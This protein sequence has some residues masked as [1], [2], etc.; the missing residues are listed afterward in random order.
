MND[1][2]SLTEIRE[3]KTEFSYNEITPMVKE[4]IAKGLITQEQLDENR[5]NASR[6]TMNRGVVLSPEEQVQFILNKII[7]GYSPEE[8]VKSDKTK[9]ITIH[10]VRYQKR[11]LIADGVISAEEAEKAMQER[12]AKALDRKHKRLIDKIKEYTELGYT[13][14]EMT[15]FI[16]EYNYGSIIEI[17]NKYAKENGWYTKEEL[18]KFAGLRK[19]REAEEAQRTFENLPLEER[20]K[21]IREREVEARRQEEE[22]R[23]RQEE[24]I[25]RRE[26]RKAETKKKHQEDINILKGHIKN[27]KTMKKAADLMSCSIEYIYRLKRES[28]QEGTWL[29]EEEMNTIKKQREKEQ[30][31]VRRK[32]ERE[33][34]KEQERRR[35]ENQ[36]RIKKDVFQ[37]LMYRKEEIPYK[38]IAKK[39]NYSISHLVML[40][41]LADKIFPDEEALKEFA[42]L[43]KLKEE[44]ERQEE[45][46]IQKRELR[47]VKREIREQ[48]AVS[49]ALKKERK[50]KIKGY[51]N[52][53]K[54]Y[55]KAAK[56]EDKLELDGEENVSTEGREKFIETL[57]ALHSL[58]ASLP[59]R[60]IEFVMN[61]FEMHPE[62]AEKD[63]IKFLIS[64][65]NKRGG[66]KSVMKM[67]TE[68][69]RTLSD[70][71]FHKSLAEYGS[72]L[73]KIALRPKIQEMKKQKMS[74]SEIAEKLGISSAEVSIIFHNDKKPDFSDFGNR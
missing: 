12:Q 23:K 49:G 32:R 17:K 8:I 22:I 62:I 72:W 40:K 53:Y 11:K 68:L 54:R 63:S 19:I 69:S 4:L 6:K 51:A 60:D 34:K 2:L 70:T 26:E 13:L 56:A 59:D 67:V 74:N 64:N 66:L 41:R 71:K 3:I 37:V 29:T 27:R 52:V 9:S 47:Q 73:K 16:K 28:I 10:K 5:K 21:I 44:K 18:A 48:E 30:E 58:E 55:K 65:A 50:R 39:M 31:K 43:L 1:G 36:F 35:E 45:Q 15:E 14:I 42:S 38:E 20:E 61:T 24:I 7:K 57:T 46:K 25:A 33:R